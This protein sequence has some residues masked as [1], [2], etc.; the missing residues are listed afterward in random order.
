[1]TVGEFLDRVGEA[2]PTPGGGS[3]AALAGA[4][5]SSLVQM[6]AGLTIGKKKYA[7]AEDE[8]KKIRG[9][10]RALQERLSALVRRDSEA[11]EAVLAAGR[12]PKATLE[13]SKARD[14]A[15]T[16]ATWGAARVPL[17]TAQLAAEVA[18]LAVRAV[19]IGNP[20]AATDAG[21]AAWMAR[22]AGEAALLNVQ[23]N[24]QSLP[25]SADKQSV[26]KEARALSARL[27]TAT[28]AASAAVNAR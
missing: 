9:E 17:E 23:V 18:V 10:A 27:A 1:V 14:E 22:A 28:D 20:N 19:E 25:D 4:L 2:T 16:G 5:A 8:M 13:E 15:L 7:A 21:S 24:L 26:E 6:V 12:L 11:F 3:V